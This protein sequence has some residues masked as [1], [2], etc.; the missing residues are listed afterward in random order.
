MGRGLRNL[1]LS[2]GMIVQL[3]VTG[4]GPRGTIELRRL[5]G[6]CVSSLAVCGLSFSEYLSLCLN[7]CSIF[8]LLPI[9]LVPLSTIYI[10]SLHTYLLRSLTPLFSSSL[11]CIFNLFVVVVVVFYPQVY[12]YASPILK[13]K[14]SKPNKANNNNNK[15]CVELKSSLSNH[16]SFWPLSQR[17]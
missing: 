17:S 16:V 8:L 4:I 11:S 14:T 7:F 9:G 5:K 13:T 10:H 12:K 2:D 3:G 15:P 6:L 1:R